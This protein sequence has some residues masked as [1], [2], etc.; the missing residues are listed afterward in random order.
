MRSAAMPSTEWLPT[1]SGIAQGCRPRR[2]RAASHAFSRFASA[3]GSRAANSGTPGLKWS[4]TRSR[5][6][7]PA[8][9]SVRTRSARLARA[10]SAATRTMSSKAIQS[11]SQRAISRVMAW[12]SWLAGSAACSAC[13]TRASRSTYRRA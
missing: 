6:S 1:F 13:S 8:F 11:A 4:Y 2:C 7:S 10:F 12:S 9:T 5:S 3:G